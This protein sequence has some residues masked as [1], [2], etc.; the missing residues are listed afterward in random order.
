MSVLILNWMRV[1]DLMMWFV[2]MWM[3]RVCEVDV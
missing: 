2:R 1:W 3:A